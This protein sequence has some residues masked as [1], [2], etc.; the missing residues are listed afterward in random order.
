[1]FMMHNAQCSVQLMLFLIKIIMIRKVCD[2]CVSLWNFVH[3]G[4]RSNKKVEH[5]LVTNNGRVQQNNRTT[6]TKSKC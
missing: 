4:H 2:D 5:F 3:P 1:M 6:D